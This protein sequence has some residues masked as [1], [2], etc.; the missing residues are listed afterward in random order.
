MIFSTLAAISDYTDDKKFN[1]SPEVSDN[2]TVINS[3][4]ED[5]KMSV[6]NE[7]LTVRGRA[8]NNNEP[9][10]FSYFVDGVLNKKSMQSM[11][12]DLNQYT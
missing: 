4:V 3:K 1:F 8:I 2:E 10:K 11:Q 9:K 5:G 6:K 12:E 7:V